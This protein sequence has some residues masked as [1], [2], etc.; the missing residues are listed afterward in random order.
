MDLVNINNMK[1]KERQEVEKYIE[2][3]LVRIKQISKL[4]IEK[5]D[6]KLVTAIV[7]A[8]GI[9]PEI[10]GKI[11]DVELT[12]NRDFGINSEIKIY[13]MDL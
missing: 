7:V 6:P 12:V 11:M 1:K 8:A 5:K 9:T 10:S 13:L 4:Y 3:V 2:K